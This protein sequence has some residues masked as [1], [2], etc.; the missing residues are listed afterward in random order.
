MLDV[1]RALAR[2]EVTAASPLGAATARARAWAGAPV[3]TS[4]LVEAGKGRQPG[5]TAGST[6]YRWDLSHFRCKLES[7]AGKVTEWRAWRPAEQQELDRDP[8]RFEERFILPILIAES[9][10]YLAEVG[11]QGDEIGRDARALLFECEP[12]LRRDLAAHALLNHA[13]FDTLAAF[14]LIRTKRAVDRLH[15]GLFALCAAYAE[16]ARRNDGSLLGTR[17]PFHNKPQVSASAQL[18]AGLVG[19]GMDLPLV[20]KLVDFVRTAQR[21]SGAWGDADGPDDVL[22]TFVAFD[23]MARLDPSFDAPRAASALAAF[24][25]PD[26]LFRALGPEAAW[27]SQGIASLLEQARRPFPE[28]FRWPHVQTLARDRK[29][30]LP[31]YAYFDDVARLFAELGGLGESDVELAFLDLAG[32]RAFNNRYGQD[33]GDEVLAEFARA[34]GSLPTSRAVRDGGD[35][36]LIVGTP[37]HGD[38]EADVR[39]LTEAWPERFRRRF[40]ADAPPVVARVLVGR[41]R[42]RE[43][44]A[45][46][47]RLGRALGELKLR[48]KEV[49]S[50]G[51]VERMP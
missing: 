18:G 38:L 21:P 20:G 15:P 1:K 39:A 23:L 13:F 12:V 26:G 10:E 37:T 27:L 44:G 16:E 25:S 19:L 3:P 8:H 41:G 48:H 28:R 42:A 46:R 45:L 7:F 34:I 43:L 5:S 35:E 4:E 40:G 22:T 17:F 24:Q 47:E 2:C 9:C 33:M 50:G 30:G 6:R 51:L 49:P 29:T 14:C 32:F 11:E 31:F 36:F